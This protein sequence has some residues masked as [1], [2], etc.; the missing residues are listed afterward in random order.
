[1]G[2]LNNVS[3]LYEGEYPS[4]DT[5]LQFCKMLPCWKLLQTYEGCLFIIYYY[6]MWIYVYLNENFNK[7]NLIN[8]SHFSQSGCIIFAFSPTMCMSFSCS[9]SLSAQSIAVFL[10]VILQSSLVIHRGLV[11]GPPK[12]PPSLRAQI[13]YSWCLILHGQIQPTNHRLQSIFHLL[14]FSD[15]EGWL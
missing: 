4:C 15:R 12:I 10:C 8:L 1:M 5:I 6:C 14:E 3:G 2:N 9:P 13:P 11:P 7:N